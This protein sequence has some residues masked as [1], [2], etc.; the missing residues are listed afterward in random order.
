MTKAPRTVGA[1]KARPGDAVPRAQS[2]SAGRVTRNPFLNF[3]RD[4]RRNTQ[5]MS[6]IE[7][8]QRGAEIW[9]NMTRAQKEPYCQMARQAERR[10]RRNRRRRKHR[11]RK[12]RRH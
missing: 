2:M 5:G 9:R 7:V 4:M 6:P 12:R 10:P 8:T 3:L 11:Q 1:A